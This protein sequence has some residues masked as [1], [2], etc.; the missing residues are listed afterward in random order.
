MC[1]CFADTFA[2]TISDINQFQ[3]KTQEYIHSPRLFIDKK[4]LV[5]LKV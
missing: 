5:R 2:E 3:Y 1:F 4:E